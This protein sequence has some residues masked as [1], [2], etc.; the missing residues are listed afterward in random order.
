MKTMKIKPSH[1]SQGA[2]VI[3]NES[4]FDPSIHEAY[5]DVQRQSKEKAEAAEAEVVG[6]APKNRGPKP[7]DSQ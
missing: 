3:I 6:D 5:D 1:E 2:Y 4:D 7:K